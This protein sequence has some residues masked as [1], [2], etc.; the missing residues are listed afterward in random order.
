MASHPP[1]LELLEEILNAEKTPEEVCRDYPELLPEVRR[2]WKQFQVID[3][4][5][6]S[7][8]PGIAPSQPIQES[9]TSEVAVAPLTAFGRYVVQRPLG[10]GGFGDVYLAY[11]AQLDRHVAVKVLRSGNVQT[12]NQE[13]QLLQEA[14]RLAALRHPGIVTVHDV[15][16][17]NGQVFIVSDYVEGPHLGGWLREQRPSWSEAASIAADVADALAYAHAKLIVHR[18]VKPANILLTAERKPV[19]VDFGL[20]LDESRAGG[21][22]MGIIAGTPWYMS[23]EQA[24]GTAHR[25][26]GRT[27]V[28][29]LGVVLYEMLTGRVPFRAAHVPELMRQVRDDEPQPP[30]QLKSELPLEVERIC[31]K[32]LAKRQE[33]R[34]TTAADFADELRGTLLA[35]QPK[36]IPHV[37]NWSANPVIHSVPR[38][39]VGRERELEELHAAVQ[40]LSFG[41]GRFL[42]V[43]GEPG[44]G[45]ST[46]LEDFLSEL[47]V[48]GPPVTI[49]RGRCSE[50]LAGTGAYLPLLEVLESLFQGPDGDATAKLMKATAPNWFEQVAPAA[51]KDSALARTLADTKA[52]SQ[53][54][55]K[56]ELAA[57]LRELSN[58][59]PLL[60]FL[61]DLHWADASTVDFLAYLGGRCEEIRALFVLTYRPTDLALSKH[62]WGPVM[63]DLQAHGVCR[64]LSLELLTRADIDR[65]LALEFANH[66][67]PADFAGLIHLRTEGSPLFIVDLLRYLRDRH[68]LT[69]G[70]DGWRLAQSIPDLG[71]DLPESVRGMIQRKIDQLNDDDR[72][73]LTAAGVQGYEFDSA[74]VAAVLERDAAE[75]EERLDELDRVH[76]LVRFTEEREFP[77]HTL[78]LRYRFVHALYQEALD[79]LLRPTRRASLSAAVANAL[80]ARYGEKHAEASAELAL[81]WEAARDFDQAVDYYLLAAQNAVRVFANQEAVTL[82]RRGLAL[83]DSLP[84]TPDRSRKELALQIA[85]GP[86]LFA[87]QEWAAPEV[88]STY[89]RADALCRKLGDSP[90]LF[91]ARWGLFLYHVARGDIQQALQL[92]EQL[93]NLAQESQDRALLLQAHHATGPILGLVGDWASSRRQLEEA[94]AYYDRKA[95][96]DHAS[97]YGGHDPCVCCQ[98]YGAKALWMLGYPDQAIQLG[99]KALALARDLG[100]PTSLAH[101][102]FSVAVLHQFRRE[103]AETLQLAETLLKLAA[104]QGLLYY[105]AGAMALRGWALAE[106]GKHNDALAQLKQAFEVGGATRA[107]WRSFSLALYAEALGKAG[108]NTEGLTMLTEARTIVEASGIR[109]YEPEIHRLTGE[110]MLTLDP[111][112]TSQAEVYFRDAVA[113]ARRDQAKSLEL[114]AMVSLAQL[115]QRTGQADETVLQLTTLYDGFSEGLLTPDLVNAATLLNRTT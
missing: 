50:R 96:A 2:R 95:H 12:R 44:I 113:A 104:D 25:I 48:A 39:T 4:H 6:R 15:G 58:R 92:G 37:S 109:L 80:L 9:P 88:E 21:G 81:L 71:R 29:S 93:Q 87:T 82:L 64:E 24:A 38:H 83:L 59:G 42:C 1:M 46:L 72:R 32:A 57:F 86:A 102:Q 63:L 16:F 101:T 62:V 8:L 115:G 108:R 20:A 36:Q 111:T 14:R 55:L 11:D 100:H 18:D 43:T 40:S 97:L 28:Y 89:S 41:S 61:D 54:R 19:L 60:I 69:R 56:R 99:T 75:V 114:R 66:D 31:L 85:L 67:F 47:A 27:D 112:A 26:D 49:A 91:R 23:P 22:A 105:L 52:A 77:D 53:E 33:D 34:F 110:L 45:K 98:G 107:H 51:A 78:T 94:V 74:V 5:V 70:A 84:D 76:A 35:A 13:E 30:R 68:V 7:L 65:Y 10:A 73:L 90:D 106:L 79:T 17:E 3:E 103:A